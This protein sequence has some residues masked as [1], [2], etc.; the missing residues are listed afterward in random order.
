MS[1]RVL[2]VEDDADLGDVVEMLLH[3]N[4]YAVERAVDG[5]QALAALKHSA[6][7]DVILLDLMMPRVDGYAFRTAQLEDS[8]IASVPVIVF[9]ADRRSVRERSLP[10]VEVYLD[11]P[12]EP[13]ALLAALEGFGA[14]RL[15]SGPPGSS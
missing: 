5:G 12:I 15:R 8:A 14:R 2:L 9:S 11:K 10:G 4:G 1:R 6:P 13:D 7:P 3:S